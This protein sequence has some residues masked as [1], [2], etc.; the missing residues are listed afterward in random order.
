MGLKQETEESYRE[1]DENRLTGE[2]RTL[3]NVPFSYFCKYRG[4]PI[5]NRGKLRVICLAEKCKYDTNSG[6]I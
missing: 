3:C 2:I 5:Q 6:G 4:E 1:I